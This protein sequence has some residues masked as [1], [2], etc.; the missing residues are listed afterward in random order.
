M[1]GRLRTWGLASKLPRARR[2]EMGTQKKKYTAGD[3]QKALEDAGMRSPAQKGDKKTPKPLP[4]P[5]QQP[6]LDQSAG[7]GGHG[8]GGGTGGSSTPAPLAGGPSAA[9]AAG[10][11]GATPGSRPIPHPAP[12]EHDPKEPG[13]K[14][15]STAISQ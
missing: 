13:H 14:L 3:Y 11:A 6:K 7:S 12:E 2:Q 9:P 5:T 10:A 8:A 15:P 1:C 4:A